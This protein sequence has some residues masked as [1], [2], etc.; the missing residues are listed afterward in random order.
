MAF[1]DL[2]VVRVT[3]SRLVPLVT[4]AELRRALHVRPTTFLWPM[5]DL[6]VDARGDVYFS[7]SVQIRRR[8]GC[9]NPLVERTAGG[10]IRE[11]QASTT[12]SNICQ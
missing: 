6:G 7:P 5:T 12:R 9:W 11:I 2:D 8:S 10:K 3:T 4:P 1:H